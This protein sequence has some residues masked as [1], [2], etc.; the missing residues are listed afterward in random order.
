MSLIKNDQLL[1]VLKASRHKYLIAGW[2]EHVAFFDEEIA[3]RTSELVH[4]K[5]REDLQNKL[6]KEDL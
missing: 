5:L 3:Y 6:E 4:Q 1:N 2:H